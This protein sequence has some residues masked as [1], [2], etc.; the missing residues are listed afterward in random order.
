MSELRRKHLLS[1][2]DL[3]V[4]LLKWAFSFL[5]GDVRPRA[6]KGAET[7]LLKKELK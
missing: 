2:G 5:S 7:G 3:I 4:P 1:E 6:G